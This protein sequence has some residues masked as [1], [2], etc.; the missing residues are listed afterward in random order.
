MNIAI[1]S[2]QN[3]FHLSDDISLRHNIL[4]IQ[5]KGDLCVDSLESFEPDLVF[6]PHWNWI[7]EKELFTRFKCIVFHT[8]PLPYGRGGSPI[9]NLILRGHKISPVCALKMSNGIDNG[10]IYDQEDI[11]LDG[12]L[13]E[14]LKRLDGAVNELMR[15]LIEHLP[16]PIEQ[17]G[18][19]ETFKR[20]GHK[21]NEISLDTTFEEVYD[22]VRMLD[23]PSYPSAYL[24]LK[25]ILIEFSEINRTNDELFCRVRISKKGSV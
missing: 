2:S 25:N 3:W 24:P 21:D 7:V 10:P 23:D 1:C 6:F 19:A 12:S 16:Q 15:R 18:V 17:T 22:A 4:M 13:C 14:I 5:D 11:S 9:Q 8:A 20:L